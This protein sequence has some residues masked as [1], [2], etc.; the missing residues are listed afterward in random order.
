MASRSRLVRQS[1]GE[2]S[3]TIIADDLSGATDSAVA[4][5]ERGL[6]TVVALVDASDNGRAEA[7]AF[8]ADTRRR[9]RDAAA[10]ETARLV[11]SRANVNGGILFKKVD[12]TL[13]GHIGAEIAALLSARRGTTGSPLR[14]TIVVLAPAFPAQGRT[15]VHGRQ[16]LKGVPLEETELWQRETIAANASLLDMMGRSGLKSELVP[17]ETVRAGAGAIRAAMLDVADRIDILVC[18]AQTDEHLT[19]LAQASLDIDVDPVWAGS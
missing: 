19:A 5:A 3:V 4:C 7:I 18:D 6:E 10:T 13:R 11:R 2:R 12:S 1:G 9:S 8:D 17:I 15:T 14:R 16:L